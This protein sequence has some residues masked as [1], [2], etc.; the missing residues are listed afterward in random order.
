MRSRSRSSGG[1]SGALSSGARWCRCSAAPSFDDETTG[2]S[3]RRS[4]SETRQQHAAATARPRPRHR[5]HLNP[6][7]VS[8]CCGAQAFRFGGARPDEVAAARSAAHDAPLGILV[9]LVGHPLPDV[10]AE[11]QHAVRAGARRVLADGDRDAPGSCPRTAPR[12]RSCPSC[13][14]R[15]RRRCPT[16]TRARPRRAPPSPIPPRW[17]AARPR[18]GNRPARRSSRRRSSAASGS[19]VAARPPFVRRRLAAL[20]GHTRRVV[21]ARDLGA[22]DRERLERHLARRPF[23]LVAARAPLRERAAGNDDA[24][25]LRRSPR[26]Q[27]DK[28]G[29]RR[30]GG[31]GP[32]AATIIR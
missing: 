21:G 5:A 22:V 19:A 24:V 2:R 18:T 8:R 9:V 10:A 12:P 11:I 13:R 29:E 17:A 25:S 30:S 32:S 16:G 31:A 28:G 3:T 27:T 1:G 23:V 4:A 20:G 7:S 14:A 15:N 6:R 26:C